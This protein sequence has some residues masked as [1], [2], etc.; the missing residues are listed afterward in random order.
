MYLDNNSIIYSPSDLTQFLASP[1]CSWMNHLSL[2]KPEVQ[3]QKNSQNLMA[4]LLID[5]G[6]LHE[7]KFLQIFKSKGLS[8]TDVS[9]SKDPEETTI[10]ASMFQKDVAGA[11]R[12]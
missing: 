10:C 1:F 3:L 7:K 5:K 12:M 8:I 2:I 4:E 6:N 11:S 9:L